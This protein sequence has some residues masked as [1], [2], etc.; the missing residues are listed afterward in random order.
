M[1]L[2]RHAAIHIITLPLYHDMMLRCYATLSL[3]RRM[4]M[5]LCAMPLLIFFFFFFSA[6][7]VT[8]DMRD[9]RYMP[10]VESY[11]TPRQVFSVM[12]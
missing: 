8:R 10:V 2:W 3:L 11:I 7:L 1:P 4:H 5:L 9:S 12:R 6:M